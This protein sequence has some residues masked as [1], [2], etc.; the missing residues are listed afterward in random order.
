MTISSETLTHDPVTMQAVPPAPIERT[1]F[2]R[3][4]GIYAWVLVTV[5]IFFLAAMLAGMEDAQASSAG[6]TPNDRVS[7]AVRDQPRGE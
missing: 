2:T 6:D 1:H 3:M 5:A 4:G 7:V